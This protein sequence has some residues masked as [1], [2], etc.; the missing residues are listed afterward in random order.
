MTSYD[1]DIKY[2][3]E[4][5]ISLHAK[6][7]AITNGPMFTRTLSITDSLDEK[8]AKNLRSLNEMILSVK[9]LMAQMRSIRGQKRSDW[10]GQEIQTYPQ[11]KECLILANSIPK[12]IQ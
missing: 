10:D 9:G 11:E 2:I 6:V 8:V 12:E 7:D 3:K 4:S 1:T 5:L